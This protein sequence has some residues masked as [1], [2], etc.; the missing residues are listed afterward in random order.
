MLGL[1]YFRA[2]PVLRLTVLPSWVEYPVV[3]SP[4]GFTT[5]IC[6]ALSQ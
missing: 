4:S 2:T 5:V 3:P 1:I 6:G